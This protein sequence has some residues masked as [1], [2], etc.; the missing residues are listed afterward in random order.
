MTKQ[1]RIDFQEYASEYVAG[2]K[3][4]EYEFFSQMHLICK[5]VVHRYEIPT[6]YIDDAVSCCH[7]A[8]FRALREYNI[9]KKGKFY[10]F[11]YQVLRWD[12]VTWM[13]KTFLYFERFPTTEINTSD[14]EDM[15]KFKFK[16][17][18]KL[19]S[20]AKVY[21]HFYEEEELKDINDK[22]KNV[23]KGKG[24]N[25]Y[26][27]IYKMW[28]VGYSYSEMA[29]CLGVKNKFADNAVQR[30]VSLLKNSNIKNNI[31]YERLKSPPELAF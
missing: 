1:E 3:E 27:L 20:Q 17:M 28:M 10:H 16:V 26:Y 11:L 8:I 12:L 14:K 31:V 7:E 21:R 25:K 29:K 15:D 6:F 19:T 18:T 13:K 24:K 22:I 2:N 5:S 30:M 23:L 9:S 4:H